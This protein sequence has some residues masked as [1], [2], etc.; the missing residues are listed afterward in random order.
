MPGCHVY[1]G[2]HQGISQCQFQQVCVH[3]SRRTPSLDILFWWFVAVAFLWMET[4][5]PLLFPFLKGIK[6]RLEFVCIYLCRWDRHP[7]IVGYEMRWRTG[8]SRLSIQLTITA[9]HS[10][11]RNAW[12][13]W[14]SIW[15]APLKDD[16]LI[17][18]RERLPLHTV[19]DVYL[20][21]NPVLIGRSWMDLDCLSSKRLWPIHFDTCHPNRFS[22]YIFPT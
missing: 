6:V 3:V 4:H 5:H 18:L 1:G 11:L 10:P 9:Q 12:R 14:F 15:R 8:A 20:R 2:I 19:R 21:T 7:R 13:H 16:S 17:S 22:V